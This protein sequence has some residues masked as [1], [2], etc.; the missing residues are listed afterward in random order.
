MRIWWLPLVSSLPPFISGLMISIVERYVGWGYS[1]EYQES[2]TLYRF[3]ETIHRI[4]QGKSTSEGSKADS[5][6]EWG[7]Y[8]SLPKRLSHSLPIWRRSHLSRK[9]RSSRSRG[10][11]GFRVLMVD[12]L[13]SDWLHLSVRSNWRIS[14]SI[15]RYK[16]SL[17]LVPSLRLMKRGSSWFWNHMRLSML[18]FLIRSFILCTSPL[19][20]SKVMADI[21]MPWP[22]ISNRPCIRAILF[23]R[24]YIRYNLA[25][26][27]VRQN[28]PIPTC[29]SPFLPYDA[30][31]KRFLPHGHH[32][33]FGSSSN[34]KS[35][36]GSKWSCGS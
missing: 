31:T 3:P 8:M 28:P 23:S 26:G 32:P 25:F 11:W 6:L 27:H 33:W 15:T 16:K 10:C 20:A 21:Q 19:V 35:I 34:I 30:A 29:P 36:R 5:R 7:Y 2:R 1:W 22:L 17:R 9:D 18:L 12:S 4:P 14:M 13:L 24:H